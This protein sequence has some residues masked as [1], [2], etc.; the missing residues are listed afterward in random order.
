M[1]GLALKN[2]Y[3][4]RSMIA[5]PMQAMIDRR[6]ACAPSAARACAPTVASAQE[7]VGELVVRAGGGS[8]RQEG[9]LA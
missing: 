7:C 6:A 8:V 9:P 5:A 3:A 4:R 1:S 2:S